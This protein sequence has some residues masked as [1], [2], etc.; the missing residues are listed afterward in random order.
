MNDLEPDVSTPSTKNQEMVL[1]SKP[2]RDLMG[3]THRMRTMRELYLPREEAESAKAY[4]NRVR[5]SVLFNATAKTVGDMTGKV[6]TKAIIL[7]DDVPAPI[8]ALAEDIDLTGRHI[9]I[10]AKDV[11]Y[12]AMQTGI[13]YILTDMPPPVTREDGQPATLA[14]EQNA[15]IRPYLVYIPMEHMLGWKSTTINGA[16]QLTMIRFMEHVSEANGEF[17]EKLVEQVKVIEPG[18]W[19]T[20]RRSELASPDGK[21]AAGD[22]ILYGA[23][24]SSLNK[25]TLAPVYINRSEYMMGLPPHEKLAEINIA[26]WQSS[27]DQRNIVHVARVPI[28]FWAGKTDDDKVVVG[29]NSVMFSRDPNAKLMYVEHSGAAIASGEQDITS[30]EN[31]MQAMGLLLLTPSVGSQT[32]TGEMRDDSKENSPLAMM[33]RSLGDALEMSLGFMAEYMGLGDSGGSVMVNTDYGIQAGSA[34]DLQW[35]TQLAVANKLSPETLWSELQRRGTLSDSF[36]PEVEQD[37]L[38]A[39]K[40]NIEAAT[41]MNLDLDPS[42]E[43]NQTVDGQNANVSY[44]TNDLKPATKSNHAIKKATFNDGSRA[45]LANNGQ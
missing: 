27:S 21:I 32:A 9:N 11:F 24:T 30:L 2:I 6:F 4:E 41:P 19:R 15:A 16:E 29:V 26:H 37:R 25:I 13:G 28:L 31:Q 23:G 17:A 44:L 43:E 1:R 8:V 20:F 22:W 40:P 34:T 3:G 36:D 42:E 33:A 10:F 38:D 14:D 12:D 7:E 18:Q 39:A 35:L 5:R 45:Y